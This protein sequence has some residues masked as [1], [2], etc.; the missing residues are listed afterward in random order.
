MLQLQGDDRQVLGATAIGNG[1]DFGREIGHRFAVWAEGSQR[2]EDKAA[3]VVVLGALR[4]MRVED[5]WRL[6]VQNLQQ[7]ALTATTRGWL[8]GGAGCGGGPPGRRRGWWGGGG[9]ASFGGRR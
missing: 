2:F 9:L 1:R 3:S 4:Q 5:G 6:P 8:G 7:A